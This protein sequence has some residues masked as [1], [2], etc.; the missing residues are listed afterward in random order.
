MFE[1]DGNNETVKESPPTVDF[2]RIK[3][4]LTKAHGAVFFV[5]QDKEEKG[6]PCKMFFEKMTKYKEKTNTKTKT[7]HVGPSLILCIVSFVK[8]TFVFLYVLDLNEISKKVIEIIR[9]RRLE[10]VFLW[11]PKG[12]MKVTNDMIRDFTFI[13][14][15]NQLLG[16]KIKKFVLLIR[17]PGASW[18]MDG[19]NLLPIN[20]LAPS[21]GFTKSYLETNSI[22]LDCW[23]YEFVGDEDEENPELFKFHVETVRKHVFENLLLGV[24]FLRIRNDR[25]ELLDKKILR[26][27][28]HYIPCG[29]LKVRALSRER[30]FLLCIGVWERK[31][32]EPLQVLVKKYDLTGRRFREFVKSKD[33]VCDEERKKRLQISERELQVSLSFRHKNLLNGYGFYVNDR[34]KELCLVTE[35]RCCCLYHYKQLL[36]KKSLGLFSTTEFIKTMYQVLEGIMHLHQNHLFLKYVFHCC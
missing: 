26:R 3:V 24:T 18:Q 21:F 27:S 34:S 1:K 33:E 12:S 28:R 19:R 7:L 6:E 29:E 10:M 15:L 30:N 32:A 4:E 9:T 5:G 23:G 31:D 8:Y 35:C 20:I 16:R 25:G 2:T 14:K 13:V 17:E 36:D 11:N 22:F